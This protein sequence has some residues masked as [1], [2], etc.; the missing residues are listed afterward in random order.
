[1]I[2]LEPRRVLPWILFLIFFAVLNETVFNVATPAITADFGLSPTGV[3]WM[4]TTFIVVFGVGSVIFGRLSDLVDLKRLITIGIVVYAAGSA[5]GFVFQ[6]S[7]PLVLVAR[8]LQGLGGSAIP[9]LVMVIVARYFPPEVRGR[10]FGAIGSVVSIALGLGP[11]LG[12]FIASTL[13]WTW[14]FLVPLATL[15]GIPFLR[16]ILPDEE[17]KPG[18]VDALGAGLMTLG[19]GSLIIWLTYPDWW[20][21]AGGLVLT[22]AFVARI[23]TAA[24]PFLK[25]DLFTNRPFRR[26]VVTSL[27]LFGVVIGFFFVLPLVLN[28]LDH[29]DTGTIGLVLFP[30]AISGVVFGPLGGRLADARGNRF[31]LAVGLSLVAVSLGAA[32]FLLGLS[33]W[34]LSADLLFTYIGFSFL[35]TG[36][37]NGVSQTLP[38]EE[39]GAG[40]GLFNLVGILAGAVGTALVA[41]VLETGL[42]GYGGIL[43]VFAVAVA[44]AGGWYVWTL[45]GKTSPSF[46][47][48]PMEL[49]P[50]ED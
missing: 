8:A 35:Q 50:G 17:R 12:G 42:L 41:R 26:G 31:V 30:G 34:W 18:S 27:F 24:E 23:L 36:L 2:T 48:V 10:L 45:S 43:A 47:K 20:W 6:F 38:P 15:A 44:G 19:L 40:M 37:I 9:A 46:P 29:L 39:T 21:L 14:L 28:R 16:R 7:Y 1:M 49:S 22:A 11:V 32:A 13:H 3:S 5:F 4:M 25:P 33:P